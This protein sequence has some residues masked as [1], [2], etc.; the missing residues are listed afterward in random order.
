MAHHEVNVLLRQRVKRCSLRKNSADHLMCHLAAAFLVGTLG[1][2]EEDPGAQFSVVVTLDGNRICKFAASV[3]ENHRKQLR[4]LFSSKQAVQSV[5]YLCHGSGGIAVSEKSEHELAVCKEQ[6][7]QDFSTFP[8]L[9][10]VHLDNGDIRVLGYKGEII[11]I[12]SPDVALLIYP[13]RLLAF[14]CPVTNLSRKVKIADR[15]KPGVYVV[16][17]RLFI[18]HD[19]IGITGTDMV[20]GLSLLYQRRNDFVN[21]LQLIGR[22]GKPLPGFAADSFIL[23]LGG[24]CLIDF[25][26]EAAGVACFTAVAHIRRTFQLLAELLLKFFAMPVASAVTGRTWFALFPGAAGTQISGVFTGKTMFTGVEL[27]AAFLDNEVA[28]YFFGNRCGVLTDDSTDL[29][30]TGAVTKRFFNFDAF[31]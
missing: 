4:K 19:L 5:E 24:F 9:H 13:Q 22:D 10:G 16:V 21:S 11:L 27:T 1:I 15:E 31:T 3:C 12:A 7:Q 14:P 23:F 26:A 18:Q 28:T 29:L 25:L 2:T 6:C 17:D 30:E 8:A 20:D